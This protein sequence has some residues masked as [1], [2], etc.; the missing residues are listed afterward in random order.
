MTGYCLP[1]AVLMR[2]PTIGLIAPAQFVDEMLEMRRRT[3][4]FWTQNLLETLA[5]C[6][7]DRPTGPVIERFNVV[8]CVRAFHDCF[9]TPTI[10]QV[11]A[12]QVRG[13]QFVSALAVGSLRFW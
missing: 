10:D 11:T 5:D 4:R 9:R 12:Y 2:L 6:I 3:R 1:F 7:A 13:M 8:V